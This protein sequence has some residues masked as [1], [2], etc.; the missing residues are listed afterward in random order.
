MPQID[1]FQNKLQGSPGLQISFQNITP[2][3]HE[4]LPALL[5]GMDMWR[6]AI[7]IKHSNDNAEEG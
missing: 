7:I 4:G 3:I 1:P 2:K 6:I 5:L